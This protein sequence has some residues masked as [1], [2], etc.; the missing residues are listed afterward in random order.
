MSLLLQ[1]N[2]NINQFF[3][4]EVLDIYHLLIFYTKDPGNAK[5][6]NTQHAYYL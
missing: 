3:K 5:I 6:G 1:L 4:S 2:L